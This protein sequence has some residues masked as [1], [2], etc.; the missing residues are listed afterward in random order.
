MSENNISD[1][2][3]LNPVSEIEQRVIKKLLNIEKIKTGINNLETEIIIN[4]V[5]VIDG[6]MLD[7]GVIIDNDLIIEIS[8][9][10]LIPAYPNHFFDVIINL[11]NAIALS[12]L[13]KN[14][15]LIQMMLKKKMDP[16]KFEPN[17]IIMCLDTKQYDLLSELI[18]SKIDV[19]MNNYESIYYLATDG[20]LD[21]IKKIINTNNIY[22]TT[23]IVCKICIQAIL[24]DHLHII[25]YFFTP[26]A[27]ET[28]PD[29]MTT[30]FLKSI[31]HNANIQII[32]F[33]IENNIL[34]QQNDYIAVKKAIEFDRYDIIKYFYEL[35][36]TIINVMSDEEKI[37]FNLISP[38]NVN[39]YIGT[40][41]FCYLSYNDIPINSTYYKCINNHF[42]IESEWQQ[43]IKNKMNWQCPHCLLSVDKILYSNVK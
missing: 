39:C 4:D 31:E 7:I 2:Q 6:D 16:T 17:I 19:S 25:K 35:D 1:T 24:N 32:K 36:H 42:Y 20:Q 21:L 15:S 37:K 23:E 40:E 10:D 22:D 41:A 13:K 33:F 38:V 5:N 8:C 3:I 43:W 9:E 12:I 29:V 27:F 14:K 26:N 28:A 11:K 18:D 34:I 30:Y